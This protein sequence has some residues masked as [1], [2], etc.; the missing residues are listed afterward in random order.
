M[1]KFYHYPRMRLLPLP[2][3]TW[4]RRT[5]MASPP[6]FPFLVPVVFYKNKERKG[7]CLVDM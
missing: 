6:S 4:K 7:I 1:V 5:P 2:P 3:I